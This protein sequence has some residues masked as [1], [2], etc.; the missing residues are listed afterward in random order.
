MT[1]APISP[2]VMDPDEI[3]RERKLFERWMMPR[4][5][6]GMIDL[7]RYSG[8]PVGTSI[9]GKYVLLSTREAWEAWLARALQSRDD[10]LSEVR[11]ETLEE[12]AMAAEGASLPSH[13][14]WGG[15]AM[16]HFQFGTQRAAEAIRSLIITYEGE[17]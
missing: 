5:D 16:G 13:F 8:M 3:E 17:G 4:L 15:E 2:A 14:Q 11:R 7:K 12:A 6:R 10:K 9:A 1:D